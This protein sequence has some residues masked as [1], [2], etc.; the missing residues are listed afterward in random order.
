MHWAYIIISIF[1]LS[2][3]IFFLIVYC[4]RPV[5]KEHPSHSP[6]QQST[7]QKSNTL[8]KEKSIIEN[9]FKSKREDSFINKS[10]ELEKSDKFNQVQHNDSI[11][12]DEF[13][14]IKPLS[15]FMKLVI[16]VLSVLFFHLYCG[17]EISFGSLLSPFAVKSNLRMTKSEGAFLTSTYWGMFTFL[18]IFSLIAITYFSPRCLLIFNMAIIMLSNVFL[19]PFANDFSWALW[20]GSALMGLGCSSVF[21]TMFAF[22]EQ[23]TPVTPRFTSIT[24]IACCLGEFI[25]PLLVGFSIEKHPE[26]FLYVIFVYSVLSLI[27]LTALFVIQHHLLKKQKAKYL[28]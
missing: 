21:A 22:V 6:T 1:N 5:T 27:V 8:E 26:V 24:M 14:L 28:S 23:L 2:V 4:W 11:P 25:I 13:T 15:P 7:P 12:F 18:R 16:V 9:S 3:L 17:L 20:I 19:L 10:L